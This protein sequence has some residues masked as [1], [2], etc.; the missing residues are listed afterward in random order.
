M[1]IVL[2]VKSIRGEGRQIKN[3][4]TEILHQLGQIRCYEKHYKPY[5]KKRGA[6]HR[7]ITMRSYRQAG[8][9]Q[10]KWKGVRVRAERILRGVF[11]RAEDSTLS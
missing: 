4:L 9:N 1:V 11:Q 10:I 3:N 6:D 5:P 7:S 8:F 2:G